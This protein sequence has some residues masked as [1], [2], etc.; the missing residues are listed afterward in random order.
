MGVSSSQEHDKVEDLTGL[1]ALY[2]PCIVRYLFYSF[3]TSLYYF[4]HVPFSE[5]VIFNF[6]P[7]D[8]LVVLLVCIGRHDAVIACFFPLQKFGEQVAFF[9]SLK[10]VHSETWETQAENSEF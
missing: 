1:K 4:P 10:K 7:F 9:S 6:F 5:Q 8:C 3:S 2:L